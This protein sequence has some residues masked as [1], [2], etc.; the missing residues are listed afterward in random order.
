MRFYHVLG[1]AI[2]AA[3]L[4]GAA[5]A[6]D[7]EPLKQM[8]SVQMFQLSDGYQNLVPVSINGHPRLFLFDTGGFRTQISNSAVTELNLTPQ[9]TR[10]HLYDLSGNS[11]NFFV[12]IEQLG[13]ANLRLENQRLPVATVVNGAMDG[14]L[15]SDMFLRY[16][17]DVDFGAGKLNYFQPEHCPGKVVY[18]QG[19]DAPVA[20]IPVRVKDN[21]HIIL[22]VKLDGQDFQALLDTGAS[23]TAIYQDVAKQAFGLQPGGA[24]MDKAGPVNGDPNLSSYTHVFKTLELEGIT[25]STPR[26][27]IV[28]ERSGS[29]ITETGSHIRGVG[30]PDE[31][32]VLGMDILRHLHVY[33]S[34]KE[35]LLYVTGG[36][37]LPKPD[38]RDAMMDK[39]LALSPD[40]ASLLNE[41]CFRLGLEN[42]NLA[43]ALQDCDR[44]VNAHP[45]DAAILDSKGLVLYRMGKYQD[46]LATYNQ[47]LMLAPRQAPSLFMR[48][49]TKRKLGD[50]TADADIAAAKGMDADA[51]KPYSGTDIPKD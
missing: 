8:A 16:D 25:I 26:V 18:W 29:Q 2:V 24:G 23:R 12:T 30:N 36:S 51:A 19:A 20:V 37:P 33:F 46:A 4:P 1:A 21:T 50:G 7:C 45:K 40:N 34:S 11:T 42:K 39:A 44:A 5:R 6:A 47:V 9:Y 38:A 41:R 27:L 35:K 22:P 15:A 49:Q 13:I 10:A 32:M 14:L 43:Q 17:F 28:P 31:Q 48:G 3:L